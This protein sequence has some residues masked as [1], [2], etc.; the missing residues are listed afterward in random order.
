MRALPALLVAWLAL[1]ASALAGGPAL[2][3][4]ETPPAPRIE[5]VMYE[6]VGCYYCKRWHDEVGPAYPRT[7]EGQFAPLRP[8][9]KHE[10]LPD[11]LSLDGRLIFTP[12]FVLT[13]DGE[14]VWRLEGYN[15]DQFF[16]PLINAALTEHT[17]FGT[18]E[19]E[20]AE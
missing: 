15:G 7:A 19:E 14:E 3:T 11:D 17:R 16:W 13:V 1:A 6:Q 9:W 10:P 8:V 2:A 12:T 20:D 4:G 5:M 18:V